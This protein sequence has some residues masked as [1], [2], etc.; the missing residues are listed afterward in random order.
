[1]G[2]SVRVG[3]SLGSESWVQDSAESNNRMVKANIPSVGLVVVLKEEPPCN[4]G[5]V[6]LAEATNALRMLQRGTFSCQGRP[7]W[8][9]WKD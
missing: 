3:S 9:L 8:Y 2:A 5:C 4:V 6:A 1:M 7:S